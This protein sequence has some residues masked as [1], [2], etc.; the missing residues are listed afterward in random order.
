MP[1]YRYF[2]EDLTTGTLL[3]ELP[4]M[5]GVYLSAN[6]SAPGDWTATIRMDNTYRTPT[7]ILEATSPGK[8]IVWVERDSVVIW[9]G[10]LW[11]RTYQSDG[12]TMQFQARTFDSYLS[13]DFGSTDVTFTDYKVNIVREAFQRSMQQ[14]AGAPF[15]LDIPAASAGDGDVTYTKELVGD[16]YTYW[17]DVVKEMV[18]GGVEYRILYAKDGSLGVRSARLEIGRWDKAGFGLGVPYGTATRLLFQYPGDIAKYWWPE[19]VADSANKLAAIGKADDASTPRATLTNSASMSGGYPRLGKRYTYTNVE[20]TAKLSA[21][22]S[23]IRDAVAPPQTNPTFA[24]L[25]SRTTADAAFGNWSLGDYFDYTIADPY[26]FPATRKGATRVTGWSLKPADSEG[27]E[28][29]SINTLN[30]EAQILQEG[31]S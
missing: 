1:V 10:I 8:T 5:Y 25:L 4:G 20:T 15:L 3:D 17:D 26:R 12:R 30:F 29:V 7:E 13:K 24:L 16:E 22:L 21:T 31:T 27:L 11:S 6:M 14:G 28:S 18:R 2:F 9:G 19:S 23:S